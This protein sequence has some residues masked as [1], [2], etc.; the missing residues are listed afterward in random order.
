MINM[1]RRT[2][3]LVGRAAP[4]LAVGT[5]CLAAC[6]GGNGLSDEE[7]AIAE[8]WADELVRD[9]SDDSVIAI[10]RDEAL[11]A[12]E[13]IVDE[14]GAEQ[15][16]AYLAEDVAVLGDGDLVYPEEHARLMAGATVECVDWEPLIQADIEAGG[17]PAEQAACVAEAYAAVAEDVI[18]NDLVGLDTE[19]VIDLEQVARDCGVEF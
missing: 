5:L 16:A 6:G 10:P 1:I 2:G 15:S 4:Y 13:K 3:A 12:T 8:E 7:Q 11:C 14:L 9:S 18:Y 19:D 17:I